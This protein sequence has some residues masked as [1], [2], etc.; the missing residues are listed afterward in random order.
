MCEFV[1]T[2]L[3]HVE[4]RRVCVNIIEMAQALEIGSFGEIEDYLLKGPAGMA[5]LDS[6]L[7]VLQ[8]T[9]NKKLEKDTAE[10]D[11]ATGLGLHA[12]K[13]N[14]RLSQIVDETTVC[15]LARALN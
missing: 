2:G 9:K 1:T 13:N 8:N 10:T 11:W 7:A 12:K 5:Y 3:G 14:V 4:A 6:E 15:I